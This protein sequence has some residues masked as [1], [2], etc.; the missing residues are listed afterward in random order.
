MKLVCVAHQ[1][2][3][4]AA[5]Q[6]GVSKRIFVAHLSTGSVVAVNP[7]LH[8]SGPVSTDAEG[9]LSLPGHQFSVPR[10]E[11]ARLDALDTH[12][13]PFVLSAHGWDARILQHEA[14]HLEGILIC[15]RG[16]ATLHY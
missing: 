9:C 11:I 7:V 13:T 14:D 3:G 1:G 6:V 12:G 4:I 8:L 2:V 10:Y 16:K 15:D 5:P